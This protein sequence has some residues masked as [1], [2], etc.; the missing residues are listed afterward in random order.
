MPENKIRLLNL[1]SKVKIANIVNGRISVIIPL[2]GEFDRKRVQL[3]LDSLF[4]QKGVDLEIVLA[5]QSNPLLPILAS[6]VETVPSF[7]PHQPITSDYFIPGKIR[8]VAIRNSTGEFIYNSDGDI[9][10]TNPYFFRDILSLGKTPI[11]RPPMRRLPI[12]NFD[13]FATVMNNTNL[14]TALGE[15]DVSNPYIATTHKNPIK[16]KV[17][18]TKEKEKHKVFLYTEPDHNIYKTNP[19]NQGK[20]PVFSTLNVHAGG[21]LMKR[22]EFE[23]VGGFCESF[24]G[25]GCHDADIQ[26]K[27]GEVYGAEQFSERREFEVLHLDHARQYFSQER[28]L[29][30][31]EIQKRRRQEGVLVAI[32]DDFS[33]NDN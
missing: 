26:W 30:N 19:L 1:Q 4:W 3:S 9:I 27:L 23:Y 10:F 5:Q 11:C 29:K 20:E 6:V 25:W 32:L 8:N 18:R 14:Q 21:T 24:I 13:E 22:R 15:L 28:W 31:R 12:E 17:F 33:K 16:M 7:I 2:F